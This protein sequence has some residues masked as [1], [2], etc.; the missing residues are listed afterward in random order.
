MAKVILFPINEYYYD[1]MLRRRKAEEQEEGED[2]DGPLPVELWCEVFQWLKPRD[3]LRLRGVCVVWNELFEEDEKVT[4]LIEKGRKKEQTRRNIEEYHQE[5]VKNRRRRTW[6]EA[7][8][9]CPPC[10]H[11]CECCMNCTFDNNWQYYCCKVWCFPCFC[12]L[13]NNLSSD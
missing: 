5:R 2:E 6:G 9:V 10:C 3:K 1:F 4:K 7:I 11:C 13:M 12:W 8:T